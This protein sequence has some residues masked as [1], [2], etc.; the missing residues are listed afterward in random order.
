MAEENPLCSK[1]EITSV[2]GTLP[3]VV[4]ELA[5]GLSEKSGGG[6][7]VAVTD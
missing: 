4:R 6:L 1:I 2:A 7:K 3:V 5:A